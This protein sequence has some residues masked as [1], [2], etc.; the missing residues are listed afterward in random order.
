MLTLENS[1]GIM[2]PTPASNP[3]AKGLYA[4]ANVLDMPAHGN[5]AAG[6]H[7]ETDN[8][9]ALGTIDAD[10]QTCLTAAMNMV[11]GY[12]HVNSVDF[13]VYSAVECFGFGN[14]I[15]AFAPDA[16]RRLEA[17]E[18]TIV[19]RYVWE[20][21]LPQNVTKS[22]LTGLKA[23]RA[24]GGL[25]QAFG[26]VSSQQPTLHFGHDLAIDLR[27]GHVYDGGLVSL[28]G[29]RIANGAGY[30]L[31]LEDAERTLYIT[32]QV[33]I[34]RGPTFVKSAFDTNTNKL[35]A[36]AVRPISVAIDE[37]AGYG[38]AVTLDQ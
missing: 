2:V 12:Q 28:N 7:F 18:E 36:V 14:D 1:T 25:E 15:E 22:P 16:T 30:A 9:L 37:P 38:I 8:L 23:K 32:G 19:E 20:N 5:L 6:M 17:A 21:V 35:F 31:D 4:V 24:A 13:N 26:N 27:D 34:W 3:R 29:S 10:E 33:T 11:S